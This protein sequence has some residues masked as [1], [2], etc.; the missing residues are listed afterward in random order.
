LSSC[1]YCFFHGDWN[2]LSFC[3]KQIYCVGDHVVFSFSLVLATFMFQCVKIQKKITS[4]NI[5]S[6]F[7]QNIPIFFF[8]CMLLQY[9]FI[10]LSF[11][12]IT[13]CSCLF[14]AYV[15]LIFLLFG[16]TYLLIHVLLKLILVF[17]QVFTTFMFLCLL[18]ILKFQVIFLVAHTL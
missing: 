15:L 5:Y 4:L 18:K 10:F 8:F 12:L 14:C 16:Y 9:I 3:Y 1:F 2:I 6:F 7:Q 13:L 17:L 11:L